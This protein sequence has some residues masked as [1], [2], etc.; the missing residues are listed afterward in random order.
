MLGATAVA[1]FLAITGVAPRAWILAAALWAAY[2]AFTW[3][4]GGVLEPGIDA[5]ARILGNVGAGGR[6]AGFSEIEALAA[7]GEYTFAAERYRERA[8]NDESVRAAAMVRRAALLAGPLA[9]PAGAVRE[10][11]ELRTA[12]AGRLPPGDD[13]LIGTTLAHFYEHRLDQPGLAMREL[14]RLL[15]TYPDSP[16]TDSLQRSLR[17]L[18]DAEP[19]APADRPT[20]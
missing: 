9:D 7:R 14:R 13:I 10:L 2:G 12:H 16:H 18:K 1:V 6:G 20:P 8:K 11:V 5:V 4:L 19:S 17:A 3:L 15:D